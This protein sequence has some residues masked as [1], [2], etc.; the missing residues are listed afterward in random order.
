MPGMTGI[1]GQLGRFGKAAG[2]AMQSGKQFLKQTKTSLVGG[3]G[4]AKWGKA[5]NAIL[6][7]TSRLSIGTAW[8]GAKVGL[9]SLG[10]SGKQIGAA[11]KMARTAAPVAGA[12]GLGYMRGR[13]SGRKAEKNFMMRGIQ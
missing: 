12:A 13:R 9:R 3:A 2:A 11:K 4:G 8:K 7:T 10:V 6:P 5:G 1:Y